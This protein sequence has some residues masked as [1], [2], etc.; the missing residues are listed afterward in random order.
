MTD[1]SRLE[2]MRALLAKHEPDGYDELRTVRVLYARSDGRERIGWHERLKVKIR[3][4]LQQR[5]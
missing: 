1:D 3:Q 4:K 2:A 5:A